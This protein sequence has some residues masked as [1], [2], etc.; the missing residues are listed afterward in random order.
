[1]WT[2]VYDSD[3]NAAMDAVRKVIDQFLELGFNSDSSHA[4]FVDSAL[5]NLRTVITDAIV[6]AFP[7]ADDWCKRCR[8]ILMLDNLSPADHEEARAL[9]RRLAAEDPHPKVRPFAAQILQ[10]LEDRAILEEEQ[11]RLR[12][13]GEWD[14]G[15][16]VSAL[17]GCGLRPPDDRR[18]GREPFDLRLEIR[19]AGIPSDDVTRVP[20]RL[21]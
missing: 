16:P 20:E 18:R 2:P 10:N 3:I 15:G 7:R 14:R 13:A 21:A 4:V 11:E 5:M 6:A 12:Q 8:L 19:L 9:L 1:M 17:P